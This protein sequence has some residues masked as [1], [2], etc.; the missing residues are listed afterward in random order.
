MTILVLQVA[1]S[2]GLVKM[3]KFD[4]RTAWKLAP[5]SVF[6]FGNLVFGLGGTK[7]LK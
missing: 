7:S 4:L 3:S 1:K 2:A 6:Y 5:L